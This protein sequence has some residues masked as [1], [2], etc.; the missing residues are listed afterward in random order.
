MLTLDANLRVHHKK[1]EIKRLR[2]NEK[3]PAIIYGRN[4]KNIPI[5]LN[6]III[7]HPNVKTQ[8]YKNNTIS[9]NIKNN[10][11]ITVKIQTIQYHPFK[12]KIIHIDFL[13]IK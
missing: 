11:S 10:S 12:S 7:Q 1:S 5:E 13:K 6:Q 3:C 2:K 8:L 9:L 4:Y